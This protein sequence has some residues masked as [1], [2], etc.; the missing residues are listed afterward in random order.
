MKYSIV[1]G[2]FSRMY[3][4]LDG[5]RQVAGGWME[6]PGEQP[7]ATTT[8]AVFMTGTGSCIALNPSEARSMAERLNFWLE[9]I[10]APRHCYRGRFYC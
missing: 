2:S 8:K 6:E 4:T 9:Q 5:V 10:K 3:V 7:V 1:P